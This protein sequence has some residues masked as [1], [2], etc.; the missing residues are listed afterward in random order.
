MTC[1]GKAVIESRHEPF[2]GVNVGVEKMGDRLKPIVGWVHWYGNNVDTDVIIP[3][4]Y[5][6]STRL[7]D[8]LPHTMEGIDPAFPKRVRPGDLIV[9]GTN[10][11]CGS[12]RETAATLIRAS[13]IEAVIAESF[14][15]IFYRNA[16]NMGL[17]VVEC[18]GISKAVTSGD[19]LRYDPSSGLVENLT[20]P[21]VGQGTVVPEFLM[22]I[23]AQG[24]IIEAYKNRIR[25]Q[26]E[27]T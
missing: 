22:Q 25:G 17:L 16:I 5:M 7:E 12:S 15:R 20:R 14:S 3:G 13:G 4:K 18:P 10:F 27:D 23:L 9:A 11:G 1:P 6:T 26:S 19:K 2:N 8:L 21:W 24:G